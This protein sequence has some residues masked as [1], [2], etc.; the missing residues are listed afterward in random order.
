MIAF[1]LVPQSSD[2][3][4]VSYNIDLLEGIERDANFQRSRA[5]DVVLKKGQQYKAIFIV[6]GTRGALNPTSYSISFDI[7][8]RRDDYVLSRMEYVA[9]TVPPAPFWPTIVAMGA[10]A[11]GSFIHAA[12]PK[13]S[14]ANLLTSDPFAL[15]RDVAVPVLTALIVYNI[16]DM[17]SLNDRIK[18]IR[19]WRSAVFVGFLC[20][21]LNEKI[22]AALEALLR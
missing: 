2:L 7:V 8:L 18:P 22:L 12:G 14:G 10:A 15:L 17:A 11:I 3:R 9:V 6:C 20:G 4:L 21:F 13:G 5:K 1:P 16:Y 19:S